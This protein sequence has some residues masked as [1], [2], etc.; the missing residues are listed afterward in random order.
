MGPSQM[1]LE[2]EEPLKSL[3]IIFGK[4]AETSKL[5]ELALIMP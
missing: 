3:S 5:Q 4:F 1:P 2:S